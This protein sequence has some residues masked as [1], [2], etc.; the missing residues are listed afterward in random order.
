M[1]MKGSG[2]MIKL[3][4]MESIPI[5]G[6]RSTRGSGNMTKKAA[7]ASKSGRM[8]PN[9]RENI[10]KGE[11]MALELSNG[12]MEVLTK[13]NFLKMISTDRVNLLGQTAKSTADNG[14]E[15]KCTAKEGPSHTQTAENM[16]ATI[17]KTR[18]KAKGHS[19]GPTAESTSA[20][21]K[22]ENKMGKAHTRLLEE[23]VKMGSGRTAREFNGYRIEQNVKNKKS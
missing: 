19:P 17:T 5:M 22:M 15:T 20:P 9:M 23:T 7:M 3:M 10:S 11:S 1:F 14:I 12:L 8:E 18:N 13:V 21:G 6:V 2:W 4:G 16:K